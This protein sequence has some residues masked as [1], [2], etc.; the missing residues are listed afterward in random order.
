MLHQGSHSS[1]QLNQNKLR[2]S[3][4]SL[5]GKQATSTIHDVSLKM[6][7]FLSC[8]IISIHVNPHLVSRN[9]TAY[10]TISIK[11]GRFMRGYSNQVWQVQHCSCQC[12]CNKITKNSH[13]FQK[14]NWHFALECPSFYTILKVQKVIKRFI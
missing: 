10:P 6:F 9:K 14:S 4:S 11:L 12:F 5:Q 7:F 3:S 8:C 13:W 2:N 1:F